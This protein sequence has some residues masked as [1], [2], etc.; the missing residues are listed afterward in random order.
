METKAH[1]TLKRIAGEFLR[2]RGC[3]ILAREVQCPLSR[4]RVDIAGYLD[5]RVAGDSGSGQAAVR[6][7]EPR[8]IMIECK[9]SRGDFLRDAE[10]IAP[11]LELREQYQRMGA[12]IEEHRIKRCEP[13]LRRAGTSLFAELD[14]WDFAASRLAGYRRV[15]RRLRRLDEKIH[16]NTKFFLM[17]R[18]RLADELYLAAPAGVVK[19]RELPAGWGLLEC[20]PQQLRGDDVGECGADW[21]DVPGLRI[22]V[23]APAHAPRPAHR[24]RLLRNIAVAACRSWATADDQRASVSSAA[25]APA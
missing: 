14:E 18:Y 16:G 20:A 25:R 5:V 9:Q 22:A 2:L 24:Q 13:Q 12:S 10:R 17:A 19:P 21:A 4:Y 3:R 6:R 15:L 1:Q 8:T 7:C 11:L 23:V